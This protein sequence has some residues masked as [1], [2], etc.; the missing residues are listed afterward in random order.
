MLNIDPWDILWTIINLLVLYWLL[1]KF[2]FGP[3]TAI[4][5]RRA[6][7]IQGDID[8]AKASKE[9][10]ENMKKEYEAD[11]KAAH[12][13]A[14]KITTDAKQRAERECSEMLDEARRDA[15]RMRADAEKDIESERAKAIDAAKDEIAGL[16][17]MAASQVLAKN[18]DE[19]SN[20]RYA[21]EL[22]SEVG[23]SDD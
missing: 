8:S 9:E 15:A 19:E 11:L 6:K 23:V 16:A 1:K 21:E 13:Q 3:V 14:V 7:M 10:S 2:L 12:Q 5:D 18:I 4:M 20:R 22:L 17:V